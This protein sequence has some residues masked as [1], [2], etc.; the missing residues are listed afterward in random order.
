MLNKSLLACYAILRASFVDY[1][2]I[3]FVIILSS[4]GITVGM[5]NQ[6]E[7]FSSIGRYPFS[8]YPPNDS[9]LIRRQSKR[10]KTEKS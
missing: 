4:S 5:E 8:K 9:I 10:K 2:K 7:F 6:V 1:F 3:H